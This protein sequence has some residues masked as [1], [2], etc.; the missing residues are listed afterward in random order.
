MK[1]RP[2]PIGRAQRVPS[3]SWPSVCRRFLPSRKML[4]KE[5]PRRGRS[6]PGLEQQRLEH[7]RLS[8][9]KLSHQRLALQPPPAPLPSPKPCPRQPPPAA[10]LPPP[11]HGRA[12][13]LLPDLAPERPLQLRPAP[14]EPEL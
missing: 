4:R 14:P 8:R 11:N 6:R 12:P 13:C 2:S 7:Q 3:I 9:Q 1:D 5:L 10:A